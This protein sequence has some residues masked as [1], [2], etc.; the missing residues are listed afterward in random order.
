MNLRPRE[1][2]YLARLLGES[3]AGRG[4]VSEE[5]L[6][7]AVKRAGAGLHWFLFARAVLADEDSRG[8]DIVVFVRGGS[9]IFLQSKSSHGKAR[10]FKTKKRK[11]PIE[12]VVVS[13]DE[14]KNLRR[15]QTALENAYAKTIGVCGVGVGAQAPRGA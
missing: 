5:L 7:A 10:A 12:V 15:A 2:R 1:R 3:S 8:I 11:E 4:R 9:Q 6:L 14:E 13:L